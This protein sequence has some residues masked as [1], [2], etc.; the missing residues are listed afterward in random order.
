MRIQQTI[1][2]HNKTARNSKASNTPTLRNTRNA[3][4]GNATQANVTNPVLIPLQ[5]VTNP[6]HIGAR[7]DNG[8]G[9]KVAMSAAIYIRRS[10]FSKYCVNCVNQLTFTK[11]LSQN[12]NRAYR[13]TAIM[14]NNALI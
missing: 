12:I 6:I 7:N 14:L 11:T 9:N 1:N 2:T 13:N 4:A 3:I 5:Y 8:Q 10:V